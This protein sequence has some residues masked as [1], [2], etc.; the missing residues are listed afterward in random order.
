[1]ETISLKSNSHGIS[2][3]AFFDLDRTLI[4]MISGRE[5]VKGAYRTGL[6]TRSGLLKAIYL[7]L[8]FRFRIKDPLKIIDHMVIWV[9]DI[10]E[11]KVNDLCSDLFRQVLISSI[12]TEGRTEIEF[13]KR[14]NA[15]T[16]ILSSAISCICRDV[17]VN[18]GIDDIICSDLEV[19]DGTFTGLPKGKICYGN[20]KAVRLQ[21]YCEKNNSTPR[22]A[23][24]YGD[25]V[26]DLP[27]LSLVGH[28][29]CVNPDRKLKKI[30]E[31]EGWEIK[32][33]PEK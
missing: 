16:V 26:S 1:M 4:G 20:E 31:K 19:E 15:K 2:Y 33:W 11:K 8:V 12:R 21:M 13:H 6:M 23:W 9:R 14:N 18:L 32:Y 17:A 10:P 29:V 27:V 3:F 22:E 7:S 5:L 25:S 30:A 28:P 24:Y